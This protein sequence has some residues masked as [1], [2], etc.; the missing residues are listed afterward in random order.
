MLFILNL[1]LIAKYL[2]SPSSSNSSSS[3]SSSTTTTTTTTTL[4]RYKTLLDKF[5]PTIPTNDQ[6]STTTTSI[7]SNSNTLIRNYYE[8][9]RQNS[10]TSS[11]TSPTNRKRR[12]ISNEYD[13]S[14][15]ND[16][17]SLP[18]RFCPVQS[19]TGKLDLNKMKKIIQYIIFQYLLGNYKFKNVHQMMMRHLIIQLDVFYHHLPQ[20]Q[21]QP[22]I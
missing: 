3:S 1:F 9:L 11:S 18:K 19:S 10:S 13:F 17:H 7:V 14:S 2:D 22:M 5:T 15:T 8:N 6:Q 16:G 4:P 20:Q 21:Q 12:S